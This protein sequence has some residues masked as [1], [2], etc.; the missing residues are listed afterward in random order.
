MSRFWRNVSLLALG[1]GGGVLLTTYLNS[2]R[3]PLNPRPLWPTEEMLD[4][5]SEDSFPAS[6]PPSW[7]PTTAMG[8][9]Y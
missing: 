3:R 2:R 1:I 5:T 8:S 4:T 7:T 9:P 6:D